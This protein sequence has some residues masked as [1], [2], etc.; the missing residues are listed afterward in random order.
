MLL[1][2]TVAPPLG[3]APLNVTV[4]VE[5]LPAV[6]LA[7][8][9]VGLIPFVK[10]PYTR[11]VNPNK[12]YEYAAVNLPIVTTA[13]SP[14]VIQF[15]PHVDV[16]ESTVQFIQAVRE[17]ATGMSRRPT[18]WIAETHTWYAIAERFANLVTQAAHDV[19]EP[20]TNRGSGVAGPGR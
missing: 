10:G 11:A 13:F 9:S 6:T 4:P 18:R 7:G 16:C 2:E 12:L 17:R 8:F 14:D 1:S 19:T 3:A 15:S 20:V 5:E